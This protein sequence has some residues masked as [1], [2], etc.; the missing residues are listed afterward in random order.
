[1]NK[2]II[3]TTMDNF[4]FSHFLLISQG[5][6]IIAACA[7]TIYLFIENADEDNAE[8]EDDN[9]FVRVV[10]DE[11][12]PDGEDPDGEDQDNDVG[13]QQGRYRRINAHVRTL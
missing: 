7:Y 11:D 12:D 2:M 10:N 1:M 13:R 5:E 9:E 4:F 8:P 6:F 3:L